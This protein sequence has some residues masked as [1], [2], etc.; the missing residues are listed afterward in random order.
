M[1]ERDDLHVIVSLPRL[2]TEGAGGALRRLLKIEPCIRILHEVP[3]RQVDV[4]KEGEERG[5][6]QGETTR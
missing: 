2:A 4:G 1:A 3:R 5:R 6:R